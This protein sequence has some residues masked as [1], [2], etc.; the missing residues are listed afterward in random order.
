LPEKYLNRSVVEAY[1][2]KYRNSVKKILKETRN[3][4]NNIII[5]FFDVLKENERIIIE[6]IDCLEKISSELG[7][8]SKRT[9]L[10]HGDIHA[11]NLLINKDSFYIID[12]D[13]IILAP[14]EKDLMF[15]GGDIG[16]K[17]KKDEEIEYFYKGYGKELKI[18][19]NL[20]KYYRYERIIQDIYEFHQQIMN[21]ETNEEERKKALNYLKNSLNQTTLWKQH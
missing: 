17:W 6:M 10:C 18:D 20:I 14:K 4:S 21:I 1:D 9:C 3:E 11:G 5:N 16:N 7:K 15:I 13:T 19:I 12:W 8:K 2:G